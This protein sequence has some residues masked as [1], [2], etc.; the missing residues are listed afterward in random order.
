[1]AINSVTLVGRAG[2]DPEVRY[3]ESGTVVA[4]LTMAVNRRNRNDEP[5]WFNLEIWGKQAQ[6]A[7]DY[8]KKG[9]L[10]GITGSFKLDSWKDRNTGEDRNKPVVRVDRLELLGS[11]RDSE[12]SNFQN[13]NFSQQ[14][15][16]NDEIPF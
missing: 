7:A 15:S 1:M 12:N 11:K 13:N 9:S 16:N 5:D 4:N 8:V 10:I 2:R 3:F 14:P 6:V